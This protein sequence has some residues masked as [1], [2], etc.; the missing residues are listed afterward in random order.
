MRLQLGRVLEVLVTNAAV[1][2][3]SGRAVARVSLHARHRN[4]LVAGR[5]EPLRLHRA[6][7]HDSFVVEVS[8]VI[9]IRFVIEE[10]N[11]THL[12]FDCRLTFIIVIFLLFFLDLCCQNKFIRIFGLTV[13]LLRNN[14]VIILNVSG[15]LFILSNLCTS[16]LLSCNAGY[17]IFVIGVNLNLIGYDII[18]IIECTLILKQLVN[19]LRVV[20]TVCTDELDDHRWR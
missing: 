1:V 2:A 14:F 19:E 6:R 9:S 7:C 20:V 13:Q 5:T 4:V 17:H 15:A 16:S 3:L 11:E 10:Q 8:Q 18:D 12:T